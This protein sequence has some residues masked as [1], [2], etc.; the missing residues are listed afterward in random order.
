M[1]RRRWR[2]A[3]AGI[4]L[5]SIPPALLLLWLG[6]RDPAFAD[7]LP[8]LFA[9][10]FLPFQLIG[11]LLGGLVAPQGR[12]VIA[13]GLVSVVGAGLVAGGVAGRPEA[14]L[15]D[16][17]LVVLA[18]PGVSWAD[19][20]RA[21]MGALRGLAAEGV[22][23]R[24]PPL[25]G[26]LDDWITLDSGV[27]TLGRPW[28]GERPAADRVPVARVW[29]VAA[30]SGLSVGLFGW[31]VT[32]PARPLPHGGFVVPP[33]VGPAAWPASADA[34]PTLLRSL[35][36]PEGGDPAP[37]PAALD[38]LPLG[39]RWSTLRDAAIYIAKRRVEPED[40]D[41]A[42]D[43]PLLRARLERDVL[44]ALLHAERP[45]LVAVALTAPAA[46]QGRGALVREAALLQADGIVAEI[47]RNLDPRTT[48]VALSDQGWLLA[49]GPG[50]GE[51]DDPGQLSVEDV[52]PTLLGLLDLPAARD[53][54][55]RARLGGPERRLD[56]WDA[57]APVLP[58][59]PHRRAAAAEALRGLG[60]WEEAP[61]R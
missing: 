52:A 40:L 30:W 2:G 31:P 27:S 61:A 15:A 28:T 55:G 26:G 6:A 24:L 48:V 17:W 20:E 8:S 49:A 43:R 35:L 1:I 58:E 13:V 57:L 3:L 54:R 5:G 33:G 53:Q 37:V 45:Q 46:C 9:A 19:V 34:L 50:L 32:A 21:P 56:T 42:L 59:D 29:D 36:A 38:L 14:P 60:Y 22:R 39:L 10:V 25:E 7:H 4:G 18:L 23:A 51:L 16:P 12:A 41:A 47:L 44:L 11:A